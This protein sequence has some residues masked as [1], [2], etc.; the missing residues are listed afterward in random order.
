MSR[1][2]LNTTLKSMRNIGTFSFTIDANNKVETKQQATLFSKDDGISLF[3]NG[4]IY[5]KNKKQVISGFI[6]DGVEYVKQLEGCF[7]IFLMIGSRF[8]VLTD[9]LN[10]RKAFYVFVD[11]TFY[12]SNDID[13]LPREKCRL[14]IDG[15]ASFISS[16]AMMN[17]LTLFK[18]IKSARRASIHSFDAGE[19]TITRY[20]DFIFTY[21]GQEEKTEEEY[22]QE[23][24]KQIIE[25]VRLRYDP[26]RNTTISLS[27]GYDA[28]GILGILHQQIKAEDLFCFS[29]ALEDNPSPI[30]DAALSKQLADQ[31]GYKHEIIISYKGDFID[32]LRN[33]AKEGK[34]I[35]NFCDELDAW[36]DLAENNEYA[37]IFAGDMS[38]GLPNRVINT[39]EDLIKATYIGSF[40]VSR[41]GR[42][43]SMRLYKRLSRCLKKLERDIIKE[44]KAIPEPNDKTDFIYLDQRLNHSLLPWREYNCGHFGLIHLPF[45]DGNLLNYIATLPPQ[46]RDYKNLYQKTI[47]NLLPDLFS[48]VAEARSTG[49]IMDWAKEIATHKN[50]LIDLINSSDSRLDKVIPKKRVIDMIRFQASRRMI[51]RKHI[52]RVLTSI[53][54]KNKIVGMVID[55][56]FGRAYD[57]D[58]RKVSLDKMILR[59]LIIRIY[60]SSSSS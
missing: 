42:F 37:D 33:N 13:N 44:S 35:A 51:M 46:Y 27:A 26:A 4:I 29:Y 14:S 5:N 1:T 57:L 36:H 50:S 54:R 17:D 8:Y 9:K 21:A 58:N 25:A 31:C 18:E 20:W 2:P 15:I 60:L 24:E 59:L 45:L 53:R 34:C 16:G 7:V 52:K 47:E 41:L 22:Q 19:I 12:I 49:Y 23:L 56:T 11:N 6:S 40:E 55:A 3:I 39:D 10:S 48:S 43:I 30:S 32:H 28:R 38:F